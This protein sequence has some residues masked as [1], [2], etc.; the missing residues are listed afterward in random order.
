[1]LNL[2]KKWKSLKR[3]EKFDIVLLLLSI[4]LTLLAGVAGGYTV[5][6]LTRDDSPQLVLS[7]SDVSNNQINLAL[8]NLK[9]NP[10]HNVKVAY[11]LN[12]EN[13]SHLIKEVHYIDKESQKLHIDLEE[14][15]RLAKEYSESYILKNLRNLFETGEEFNFGSFSPPTFK[16]NMLNRED[17]F[18]IR[19]GVRDCGNCDIG[20]IIYLPEVITYKPVFTC[21]FNGDEMVECDF[22]S[23]LVNGYH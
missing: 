1:M 8:S 17:E 22:D 9:N 15:N 4:I 5:H 23:Y 18:N 20:E 13:K 12:F 3:R 14:V 10:A 19:I 7:Y 21:S 2:I 16:Y 11:A 6:Y